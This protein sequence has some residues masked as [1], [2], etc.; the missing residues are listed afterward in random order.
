[1]IPTFYFLI[2]YNPC[3][4]SFE[5]RKGYIHSNSQFIRQVISVH[6]NLNCT[7]RMLQNQVVEN[8]QQCHIL[9]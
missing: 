1:M 9:N 5:I 7:L 8:M 4:S 2:H 6:L 3:P